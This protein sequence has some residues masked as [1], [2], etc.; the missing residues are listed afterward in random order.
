MQNCTGGRSAA[1]FMHSDKVPHPSTLTY[2]GLF[3]ENYFKRSSL[4]DL[5]MD[6][7]ISQA[8]VRSQL[9]ARLVCFLNQSMME[10]NCVS[11]LI[12]P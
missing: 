4:T 9:Q 3:S 11:L 2:E 1:S 6:I 7:E 8:V 5:V 10:W 12:S